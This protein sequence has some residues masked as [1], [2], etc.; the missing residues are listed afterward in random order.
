MHVFGVIEMND[1]KMQMIRKYNWS[2]WY[3]YTHTHIQ[4]LTQVLISTS[5]HVGIYNRNIVWNIA[6][7]LII[8]QLLMI[9]P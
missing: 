6:H 4:R 3:R 7:S 9:L 8:D 2:C 1:W 5:M